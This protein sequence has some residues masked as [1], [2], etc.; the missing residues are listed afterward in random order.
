MVRDALSIDS[1]TAFQPNWSAKDNDSSRV[2]YENRC[3]AM[4]EVT[5]AYDSPTPGAS[6]L[7]SMETNEIHWMRGVG[8]YSSAASTP[9]LIGSTPVME[10]PLP[11]PGDDA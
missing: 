2:A 8:Q 10:L 11:F 6:S 1:G 9:Q 3:N 4:L 7:D 5:R